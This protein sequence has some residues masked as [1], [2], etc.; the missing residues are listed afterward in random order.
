LSATGTLA[1]VGSCAVTTNDGSSSWRWCD[2]GI[3]AGVFGS[4]T[5]TGDG[6]N[7]VIFA[8]AVCFDEMPQD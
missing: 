4:A 8:A 1:T 2:T 5:R 6:D 7:V 3:R